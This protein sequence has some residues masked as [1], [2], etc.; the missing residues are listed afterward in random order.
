MSK[1]KTEKTDRMY[2]LEGRIYALDLET[3]NGFESWGHANLALCDILGAVSDQDY[4][5][6]EPNCRGAI[7]TVLLNFSR[8]CQDLPKYQEMQRFISATIGVFG[9][10]IL[11]RRNPNIPLR[12]VQ[13]E[14]ARV[15]IA[16]LIQE[17]QRIS[18]AVGEKPV[19]TDL[20]TTTLSQPLNPATRFA[21][22]VLESVSAA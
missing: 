3:Y 2:T 21:L 20:L 6:I 4:R 16:T 10:I 8:S 19:E 13:S 5:K 15:V 11:N 7:G 14:E 18:D 9:S 1:K 17:M 12:K 22:Q